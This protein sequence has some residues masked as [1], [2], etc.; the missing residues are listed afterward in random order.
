MKHNI[1]YVFSP[2]DIQC[3][4]DVAA[5]LRELGWEPYTYQ[6][7]K[8]ADG[9]VHQFIVTEKEYVELPDL[10]AALAWVVG[11]IDKLQNLFIHGYVIEEETEHV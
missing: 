4:A 11:D 10:D 5:K 6:K 1:S 7:Y 9:T 8:M 2:D 3:V